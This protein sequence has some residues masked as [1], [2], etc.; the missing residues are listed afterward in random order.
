MKKILITSTMKRKIE[1]NLEYILY[2]PS[3]YNIRHIQYPLIVYFH[4]IISDSIIES[5]IKQGI[6]GVIE[7]GMDFNF[8]CVAPLCPRGKFWNEEIGLIQDLVTYILDNYSIDRNH[9][10]LTGYGRYAATGIF[11]LARQKH[12]SLYNII[13][14]DGW[15]DISIINDLK[16][17]PM[18]IINNLQYS[19]ISDSELAKYHEN[20]KNKVKNSRIVVTNNNFHETHH[21][22]YESYTKD[23]YIN[24]DIGYD[25]STHYLDREKNNRNV[26]QKSKRMIDIKGVFRSNKKDVFE[27]YEYK[28]QLYLP[29]DCLEPNSV[30]ELPII[31]YLHGLSEHG[32]DMD[33]VS[34]YGLPFLLE[35]NQ[36]SV[37]SLVL[38]PQCPKGVEWGEIPEVI[39][40]FLNIAMKKFSI[41]RN[42]IFLT[43]FS[44]GAYEAWKV[45]RSHPSIFR[46]LVCVSGGCKLDNEQIHDIPVR[47]YHGSNDNIVSIDE[48]RK[49]ADRI[50]KLGC[51]VELYEY[52]SHGHDVWKVAYKDYRLYKWLSINYLQIEQKHHS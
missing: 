31:V 46:A 27:E 28:A 15:T 16:D 23:M 12:A 41:D 42:K 19:F 2:L 40:E 11:E 17:S 34:Q 1:H 8:A 45:I 22:D 9:V 33:L 13:S 25:L 37:S 14:I 30:N 48:I 24:G 39:V 36:L 10:I 20:I 35:N 18:T 7:D 6:P 49:A 29:S 44:S 43:G 26:E 52:I 38:V 21:G 47:F 50:K 5:V 32:D 3:D 51:E 4:T